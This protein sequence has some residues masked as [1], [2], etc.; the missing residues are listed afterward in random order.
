VAPQFAGGVAAA[1][2]VL[3]SGV[4]AVLGYNDLVAVGMLSRFAARGVAVPDRISVMGFDDIVLSE[5]VNPSLTTLAQPK[6]Q[7]GRS[8]VDLL[9][10]LLADPEG[11]FPR[12][13]LESHL[14]VRNS[15]GPAPT[16]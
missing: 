2:Q 13:E 7:T 9:L 6:E 16:P 8:G 11:T 15:T 3:A 12:R 10:Q 1:D 14:M 5:M 4:T